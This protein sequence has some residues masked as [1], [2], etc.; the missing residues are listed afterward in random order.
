MYVGILLGLST[1]VRLVR[2][3]SYI[4]RKALPQQW[5]NVLTETRLGTRW[6]GFP[7]PMT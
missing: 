3:C 7:S 5:T 4:C 2:T 6:S 1:L